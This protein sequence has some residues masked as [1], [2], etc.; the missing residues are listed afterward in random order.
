LWLGFG[1]IRSKFK[2][3]KASVRKVRGRVDMNSIIPQGRTICISSFTVAFILC[4]IAR[5]KQVINI[6][7]L[8]AVLSRKNERFRTTLCKLYQIAHILEA[9]GVMEKSSTASE[10]KLRTEYYLDEDMDEMD[11]PSCPPSAFSVKA[12][13]V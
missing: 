8:A 1:N 11:F 4:F 12:L 5:K 7:R 10:V 2:K 6:K 3:L 13:L 9:L